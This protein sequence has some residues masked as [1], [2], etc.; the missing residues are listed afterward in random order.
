MPSVGPFELT[1]AEL[2]GL[3]F[4]GQEDGRELRRIAL[5]ASWSGRELTVKVHVP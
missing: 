2:V 3:E 5:Q 4:L 1:D